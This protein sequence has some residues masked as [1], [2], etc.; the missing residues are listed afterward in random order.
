MKKESTPLKNL[1]HIKHLQIDTALS[2]LEARKLSQGSQG[3]S[4]IKIMES[5]C[6]TSVHQQKL[7]QYPHHAKDKP[8]P[9]QKNARHPAAG[10]IQYQPG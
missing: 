2:P 5:N 8:I 3:G 10:K 1:K 4:L 6:I 9:K 7:K